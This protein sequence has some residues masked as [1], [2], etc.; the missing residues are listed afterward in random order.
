[1]IERI[2]G[3]LGNYR[4]LDS[5]LDNNSASQLILDPLHDPKNH[6]GYFW[7]SRNPFDPAHIAVLPDASV[8]T[9][10]DS[11]NPIYLAPIDGIVDYLPSLFINRSP[12]LDIATYICAVVGGCR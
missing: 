1:M 12:G 3:L 8:E 9:Q 4:T 7:S 11:V 5:R 6:P 10:F 2:Q